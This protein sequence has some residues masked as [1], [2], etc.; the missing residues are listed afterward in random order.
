MYVYIIVSSTAYSNCYLTE[1]LKVF[2]DKNDCQEYFN[3]LNNFEKLKENSYNLIKDKYINYKKLLFPESFKG[4]DKTK[5][6]YEEF[7]FKCDIFLKHRQAS[8]NALDFYKNQLISEQIEN[9]SKLLSM[10]DNGEQRF[11]AYL[12]SALSYNKKNPCKIRYAIVER[13][14]VTILE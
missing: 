6:S 8:K 13:R 3:F 11:R 4:P 9:N 10:I 7:K 12:D 2:C 14:L 5:L 1:I